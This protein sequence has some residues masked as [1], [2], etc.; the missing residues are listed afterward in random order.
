[1]LLQKTEEKEK[2]KHL[3]NVHISV[4]LNVNILSQIKE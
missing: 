1:M 2:K 4:F 3:K